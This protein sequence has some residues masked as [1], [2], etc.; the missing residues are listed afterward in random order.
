MQNKGV[1]R[2][3]AIALALVVIYQLSFTFVTSMVSSDAEEYAEGIVANAKESEKDLSEEELNELKKEKKNHYLDSIAGEPVYNFIGIREFTYRE[4]QERE[5]NLGLDL[6][7]GMNVILEISVSDVIKAL[8][9]NSDDP[10]FLAAL[11]QAQEYQKETQEDFVTLFGRAYEEIAPEGRL[12]TIFSTKDLREKVNF[13]S[14]NDEVLEVIRKETDGAISNAFNVLRNRIDRFGVAQPVIQPL[15]TDGQILIELPGIKNPERVRKLLKGTAKLE[16]WETYSNKEVYEY[17]FRA[18]DKI[19]SLQKIEETQQDSVKAADAGEEET[20]QTSEEAAQAEEDDLLAEED[21]LLSEDSSLIAEDTT[22]MSDAQMRAQNPLF[23]VLMPRVSQDGKLMPGASVGYAHFSDTAQVNEYLHMQEVQEIFPRSMRIKFRWNVQP[24][25]EEGNVYELVA[26]KVSNMDGEPALSGDVVTDARADFNSQTGG[27]AEVSMSMNTEGAK[28][29]ARLTRNNIGN[30][31]A[32]VLDNY[33]YSYPRVNQEIKGGR[34]SIT[35][36]FSVAEAKDLANVLKSGKLPAPARIIQEE[37]VGPS[38]GQESITKGLWSFVIAFLVVMLYMIFYYR[39]AGWV[40][41]LALVINMFF[42]TGIL[43]SLGAVLTLPGIAGIVLTIGMSVD[44]NVLIYERIKEELNAGKGLRMALSDGYKNAYSA[45]IDSNLTTLLTAIILGYFGKG[46]IYGFAITLGIGIITSL[47]SAI[48]ITRLIYEGF[49]GKK[50]NIA[51]AS[52]LT[53]NAFKNT[54][55]K[56]IEKRKIAYVISGIVIIIGVGSLVTRGLNLGVDFTGGHNYI[57]RFQDDVSVNSIKNDLED[58]FGGEAPEVKTFGGNNQIK[59]TTKYLIDADYELTEADKQ[60]F[61]NITGFAQDVE[62]D[63]D[64]FVE[65]KLYEGLQPYLGDVDYQMFIS[66]QDKK[67]GRMSSQKVGPTIADDIKTSAVYAVIFSLIIIFLYILIRFSNWQFGLGAVAALL[68]D[69]LFILGIYS[70]FYT[71]MP[72]SM[73]IDQ[74]F[75]AAILTVVGYSINDTVVVFDRI[76]EYLGLYK[77]RGRKEIL[78]TALNSTLARTF[79]TSLSTF[80]VLL[81]IFIFGGEMIRGFIFAML[82]GVAV[83][84]YSS[85]FIA[86]PVVYDTVKAD[87]RKRALK[88]ARK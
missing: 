23:S 42:I 4:C 49:L 35:G 82:V 43:A 71:I 1:I 41:N 24:I 34:S 15:E 50:K 59:V 79:S 3:I 70:L 81:T 21:D 8:S 85:L 53:Q 25:D 31:I 26:L 45:I 33:V 51:F 68:H 30:Q 84:T 10:D 29:W 74:S 13:N 27:S 69:V 48:F 19:R 63:I 37:I 77:K 5:I 54:A 73:E 58:E 56:F 6:R 38:L 11:D 67:V 36:Q 72:F 88:G 46:P 12:A 61:Y 76:R 7:G 64:D 16:F 2:F 75:I 62:V 39:H 44:A 32:I 40:A 80:V 14:T 57:V 28:K 60:Q 17:L 18:N 55:V 22:S 66:D 65:A 20:A 86:T 78:N 87:E 47:F 52:K 9:G 83:G